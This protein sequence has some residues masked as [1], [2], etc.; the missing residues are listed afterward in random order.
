[1]RLRGKGIEL[2]RVLLSWLYSVGSCAAL[3]LLNG[4]DIICVELTFRCQ[5]QSRVLSLWERS[6]RLCPGG[7]TGSLRCKEGI[8]VHYT[9]VRLEKQLQCE[10]EL[11]LALA[12][13]NV[14][15]KEVSN[16][17]NMAK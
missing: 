15:C 1:M 9:D 17:S 3:K 8:G 11:V 6:A 13:G 7:Y 10:R 2:T 5:S 4:M 14:L 12:V 16:E